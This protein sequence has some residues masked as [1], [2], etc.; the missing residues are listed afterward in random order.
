MAITVPFKLFLKQALGF[1]LFISICIALGVFLRFAEHHL[2]ESK[3]TEIANIIIQGDLYQVGLKSVQEQVSRSIN[4]HLFSLDVERVRE[5]LEFLPWVY[6]VSVRKRWPDS[7]VV[8]IQ[9]QKA[10]AHWN[11]DFYLNEFYEVFQA[12]PLPGQ[13]PLTKLYGEKSFAVDIAKKSKEFQTM[14]K[15]SNLHID[16]VKMTPRHAWEITLQG[17]VTLYAGQHDIVARLQ[18]F[19]A[20]YPQIEAVG[21]HKIYRFAL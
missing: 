2:K 11:D 6:R 12:P 13:E 14:F 15:A 21:A 16:K 5:A 18:R 19:I 7:L 3:S 1:V 20:L 10:V 4:G 9:E 8:Y 17:G